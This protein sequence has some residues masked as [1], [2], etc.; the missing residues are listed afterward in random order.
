M[1]Q[2]SNNSCFSGYVPTV[3]ATAPASL[4]AATYLDLGPSIT[5]TPPGGSP[6][7][8]P[9]AAAGV[10]LGKNSAGIPPGFWNFATSGGGNVG[11][12]N[13]YFDIPQPVTWTNQTAL[14]S[15]PVTRANGLTITW[16][17][18][19][20]LNGFVDI[21][22]FAASATG[23]YLVGYDCS[24]PISQGSFTIPP[25][26]LLMM[27]TGPAAQATLQV[28][29]FALPFNILPVKGFD[30]VVNFSQLQTLIPIVYQ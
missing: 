27:P 6:F 10:F 2:S 23:T 29:T 9:A 1:A 18:G 26:V 21:Q 28:S 20:P 25:S 16:T 12:L 13:F 24:A 7:M 14:L 11:P 3:T 15:S 8:L 5:L 17:G 22:G 19:D 4:P 30:A